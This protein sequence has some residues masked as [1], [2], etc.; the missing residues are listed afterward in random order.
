MRILGLDYGT[1]TVGVA[2]SDELGIT[3]QPLE[4][5]VRKD[6]NKLRKT[7]ARIEE[8]VREYGVETI[9]LGFPKNMNNTI[10]ERGND[11]ID[12]RDALVRRTNVEVILWD[13]RLTTVASEKVL[14]ESGVRRENR[15]KV[16]DQIAASLILQGYL[17]SQ[18][19]G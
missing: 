4:T 5:I 7:Y 16:I 9:V 8:L 17:D 3:A 13:E 6:A 15:K 11:T 19:E 10:G 1:R 12:F 2:I 14:M 18:Q